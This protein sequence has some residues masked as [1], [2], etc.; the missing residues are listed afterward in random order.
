MDAVPTEVAGMP[1]TSAVAGVANVC[2]HSEGGKADEDDAT[3]D[4]K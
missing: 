1:N 2:V 3:S 4:E